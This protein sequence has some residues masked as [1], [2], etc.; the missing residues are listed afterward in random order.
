MK[1]YKLK[2]DIG[3]EVFGITNYDDG[4]VTI[5]KDVVESYIIDSDAVTVV[6][7]NWECN[8]NDTFETIE[9]AAARVIEIFKE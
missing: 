6:F 7:N 2:F 1:E 5:S 8:M 9:E 4:E 3:Q